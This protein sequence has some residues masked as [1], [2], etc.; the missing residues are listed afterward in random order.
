MD[1][2]IINGRR[3]VPSPSEADTVKFYFMHDWHGFSRLRGATLDEVVAHADQIEASAVGSY[4]M[5]CPAI[6]MSGEKE[7]RRVGPSAHA[8]GTKDPKDHW[9]EEKANLRFAMRT[10]SSKPKHAAR[11]SKQLQTPIITRS[12]T[13]KMAR[14]RCS[15]CCACP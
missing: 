14:C 8:R 13:G 2:V 3:Y 15:R 10:G 12:C 5:L 1:E 6:L 9:N 11:V 4:G 7:V